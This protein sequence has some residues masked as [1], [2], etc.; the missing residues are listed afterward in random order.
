MPPVPDLASYDWIVVSTSGGKDS[1][2]MII[3]LVHRARREGVDL[4]RFVVVHADL[5]RMEWPGTAELA[6]EHARAYGLR[7]ETVA[8]QQDL[9]DLVRKRHASLLKAGRLD[10]SPWPSRRARY[11]TS[12]LKSGPVVRL[13]TELV[14]ESRAAGLNRRVR[15]LHCLGLRAEESP[16]RAR[17]VPFGPDPANWRLPP[18][19]ATATTS[20][21]A[22][23]PHGLRQV[24]RWLP[25]HGWSHAEVWDTIRRSG[26]PHHPAYDLGLPRASCVLCVLAG[27]RWLV[28]GARC[29]P[30]LAM[31]YY[32]VE[33]ETGWPF[34]P[35]VS[36][37]EVM[38]EAGMT[39]EVA[40]VRAEFP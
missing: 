16:A 29:D 10:V 40:L 13:M 39:H 19:K 17:R 25:I 5:G 1:Q 33:L 4:A 36:I 23:L 31:A 24:D 35:D 30:A 22:G 34:R 14:R 18:K 26:L 37:A 12:G 38:A 32:R 3:D 11:C 2:A 28:I 6:R 20:G 21:R 27:R 9:L 15:L 8:H 7:F